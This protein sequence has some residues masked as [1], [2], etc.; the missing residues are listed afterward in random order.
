MASTLISLLHLCD[1]LFPIGGFGYS[2]G[3]EAATSS[4]TV[5]TAPDLPGWLDACLDETIG[6]SDGPTVLGA[7]TALSTCD[8]DALVVLD[9][10]ATALRP[11]STVRR[12]T[13]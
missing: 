4:G 9:R 5:V 10:E 3:L 8:W 6:R 13:R 12:S 11:S 7:W 1:S 2:D